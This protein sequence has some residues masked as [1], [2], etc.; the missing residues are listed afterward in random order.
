MDTENNIQIEKERTFGDTLSDAL[1]FLSLE[2]KSLLAVLLT[3]VGPFLLITGFLVA[4]QQSRI[5]GILSN[6]NL[7]ENT[8]DL[9]G[10][11]LSPQY[12]LMII[13][14]F[15]S[16][17]LLTSAVLSYIKLYKSEGSGNFKI[18]DV[19]RLMQS[20]FLSIAGGYILIGLLIGFSGIIVGVFG[21][22]AA[23]INYG[24]LV[25]VVF[26]YMCLGVY[27]GVAVSLFPAAIVLEDLDIISSIKRSLFLVKDYWW[28][29]LGVFLV[30]TLL[31]WILQ[32]LLLLVPSVFTGVS[33]Y[34]NVVGMESAS[35][36]N[37]QFFTILYAIFLAI[38]Y[39]L[40][41]IPHTVMAFHFYSQTERK[42]AY[43]QTNGKG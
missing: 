29:T 9:Y 32:Y 38:S 37:S 14:L 35:E 40:F 3:Y 31:T 41:L 24:F 7:D 42:K 8:V 21:G 30:I 19:W 5:A 1:K 15:V 36:V 6:Q 33:T 17:I 43:S 23:S 22:L 2:Y 20:K 34:N 27:A 4:W 25:L 11:I 13:A 26:I 18:D 28:F 12:F 16:N 10:D 39:L